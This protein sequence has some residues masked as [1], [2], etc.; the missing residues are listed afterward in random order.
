M[1]GAVV[2]TAG[3]AGGLGY[4][5]WKGIQK[6]IRAGPPPEFP[7]AV[8]IATAEMRPYQRTFQAVGTIQAIRHITVATEVSGKVTH[9][10]YESGQTIEEG[11]VILRLD[12]STEEA[13][14]R[15]AEALVRLNQATLDRYEQVSANAISK[16][17]VDRVRAE[18]D[19]SRARVEQLKTMIAK[20]EIRAPFAGKLGMRDV[21]PGQYL[22]QGET[23]TTLQGTSDEVYVDFSVPQ[24][25][26]A[27]IPVGGTVSVMLAGGEVA[28]R[29]IASDPRID[30]TTRNARVRA[31]MPSMQ[32][33][34]SPGMFVDVRIPL[35]AAEEVLTIPPTAVRYAPFGSYTF[36]VEP[37]PKDAKALRAHQRFI[38]SA[39]STGGRVI[40]LDGL[41]AGERVA[42]DGAFKLHEGSLVY[43][44]PAGMAGVGTNGAGASKR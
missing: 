22:A 38:K 42:A 1:I 31:I 37:D 29:V 7:E 20:K 9:V 44:P 4:W 19:Q 15:A 13:D 36:V 10:G 12:T 8:V 32:G 34:L 6:A 2:L 27:G 28:A 21:Q 11:A 5:K 40:I 43:E 23:I 41:K 18:L 30:M 39:G 26:A 16:Q 35:G 3:V 25:Q 17:E 33:R 14:L 24:L